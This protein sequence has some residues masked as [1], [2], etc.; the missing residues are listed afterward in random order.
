MSAANL[1]DDLNVIFLSHVENVGD[2][3]N[4]DYKLKTCGKMLDNVVLVDGLFTYIFYCEIKENDNGDLER[5]FR[6]NTI[7]GSDTCKTPLGCF[8]DLY[9]P[10]DLKLVVDTIDA[11]NNMEDEEEA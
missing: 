8:K 5:M 1:R 6:T 7:N 4:P 10:N 9:I 3:L 2:V 11:Y